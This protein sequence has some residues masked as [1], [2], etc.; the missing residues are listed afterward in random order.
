VTEPGKTILKGNTPTVEVREGVRRGW[1]GVKK[2]LLAGI[3]VDDP[4]S[5]PLIV[6][7]LHLPADTTILRV[8]TDAGGEW[9]LEI[10]HPTIPG[11]IPGRPEPLLIPIY[12]K[13]ADDLV[14]QAWGVTRIRV[15]DR[16]EPIL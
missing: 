2:T 16:G 14:F 10:E 6:D 3:P 1:M 7:R 5:G 13:R 4:K 12:G 9:A 11:T 8:F 15:N